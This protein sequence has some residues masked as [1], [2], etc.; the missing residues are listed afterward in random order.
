MVVQGIVDYRMTEILQVNPYLVHSAVLRFRE[1]YTGL[2][3]IAQFVE[4]GSAISA[5]AADAADSDFERVNFNRFIND[6]F[7]VREV[8]FDSTE[9]LF[10]HGMVSYQL[11]M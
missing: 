10:V 9:I 6:N 5:R 11:I 1:D 2:P 4:N 3:I 7:S 8:P